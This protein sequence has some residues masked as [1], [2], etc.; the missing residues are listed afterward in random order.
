MSSAAEQ[1]QAVADLARLAQRDLFA[2]W[3][4]I[5]RLPRAAQITALSEGLPIIG[6]EY[7]TAAAALAADWYE[8]LRARRVKGT[9]VATMADLPEQERW[10]SMA[11]WATGKTETEALLAGGLQ[12]SVADMHRLTVVRSSIEDPR[13]RGWQRI[14]GGSSCD[15]CQML[16]GRGAV[17]TTADFASHDHCNCAAVPEFN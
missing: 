1:R 5:A 6:D 2:L 16:I 7:G 13:A 17:Y 15:F 12:R 8:A 3:A 10:D 14:G 11:R 9:F 4:R